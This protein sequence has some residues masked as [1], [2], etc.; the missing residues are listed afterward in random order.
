MPRSTRALQV[1][2]VLVLAACDS[3]RGVDTLGPPDLGPSTAIID[4]RNGGNAYFR[5]VPPTVAG[6]APT[7][8]TPID[9]SIY[10]SV[11]IC[12]LVAGSCGPV[13]WRFERAA[14]LDYYHKVHLGSSY[15][16][17]WPTGVGA[18]PD[19]NY[20]ATVRLSS[21][22]MGYVDI[23]LVST[24][25]QLAT[26]D[27][28]QFVGGVVGSELKLFFW[29]QKG[30][31]NRMESAGGTLV[32]Q[33]GNVKVV[34]PASAVLEDYHFSV[35]PQTP[36][37]GA[38]VVPGSYYEFAPST[39]FAKPVQLTLKY[40]GAALP[41]GVAESSLKLLR[42]SNGSWSEVP[43]STVDVGNDVATGALNGFSGYAVGVLAAVLPPAPWAGDLT[44]PSASAP[45]GA[46]RPALLKA[47]SSNTVVYTGSVAL[48]HNGA[49]VQSFYRGPASVTT[50]NGEAPFSFFTT[51]AGSYQLRVTVD[52]VPEIV[53]IVSTIPAT[54]TLQFQNVPSGPFFA[55]NS[56]PTG[57]I[58]IQA[59]NN[60]APMSFVD[61]Q[62]SPGP[63]TNWSGFTQ[64]NPFVGTTDAA[65]RL[66]LPATAINLVVGGNEL[67]A[68]FIGSGA[69]PA[70]AAFPAT[71]GAPTHLF[72]PG[73]PTQVPVN[74]PVGPV[75][76]FVRDAN[77]VV[78][79]VNGVT[80]TALLNGITPLATA[81]TVNGAATFTFTFPTA[82]SGQTITF[83]STGLTSYTTAPFQIGT[84]GPVTPV[85][86]QA[87]NV[88]EDALT[89]RIQS[90][91]FTG[92]GPFHEVE[93]NILGL[94]NVQVH[95]QAYSGGSTQDISI[96]ALFP[97]VNY[98]F[99]VRSC[100]SNGCSPFSSTRVFPTLQPQPQN[101][102]A[103]AVSATSV[104]LGWDTQVN[105]FNPTHTF[106][107]SRQVGSGP[108]TI[109]GTT[110]NNSFTTS[111][112]AGTQY[113]FYVRACNTSGC[114]SPSVLV[115]NTP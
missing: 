92:S 114:S 103:T 13:V 104:T 34:F 52:G 94:A 87:L 36:P 46:P 106:E 68:N 107:V 110:P 12:E 113:T 16:V 8:P 42:F 15:A 111:A 85:I 7:L 102:A 54:A 97:G 50:A 24:S 2:V 9:G 3:N 79:P 73:F 71:S 76:V 51:R 53:D 56:L 82:G 81:P 30:I 38:T 80:V 48:L 44:V 49:Q 61:V 60:G 29:I 64:A 62:V 10:P 115:V 109:S 31:F 55:G 83:S 40:N 99:K 63:L 39:S 65:G 93:Y 47:T 101:L 27:R 91:V 23:D 108:I 41:A 100:D 4:G 26:V 112:T 22:P 59:M 90:G 14:S 25:A 11:E 35:L 98:E 96:G 72:M 1:F 89:L 84:P 5:F 70:V 32:T 19:K 28:T 66:T 95:Q 6:A 86:L 57:G 74:S 78:V 37:A 75:S 18:S 20:R 105:G 17:V 43:G 69:P 33:N 21:I 67:H 88:M 45:I 58:V 77:N